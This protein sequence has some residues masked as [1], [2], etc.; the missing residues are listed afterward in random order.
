MLLEL[1][2]VEDELLVQGAEGVATDTA[3]DMGKTYSV[4][5]GLLLSLRTDGDVSSVDSWGGPSD[6]G[7]GGLVP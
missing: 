6:V 1:A 4:R 2:T 5:L 7:D 3:E